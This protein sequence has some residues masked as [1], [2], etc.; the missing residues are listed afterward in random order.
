M[1][2][3]F[4]ASRAKGGS[5]CPSIHFSALAA[6]V[7]LVGVLGSVG[8]DPQPEPAA[9]PLLIIT[10]VPTMEMPAGLISMKL[11]PTFSV[12]SVPASRTTVIPAFK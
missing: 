11:P 9:P 5:T 6:V 2:Q 3:Q 7:G 12:N 4:T 10:I 8:L 1:L